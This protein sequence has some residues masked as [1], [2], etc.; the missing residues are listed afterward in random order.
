MDSKPNFLQQFAIVFLAMLL[1]VSC[2]PT[3]AAA[4][5]ETNTPI[6]TKT[7]F[8]TVPAT[9][10][11]QPVQPT[12]T[13]T[14]S[15]SPTPEPTPVVFGP[16]DFPDDVNPLTGIVVEDPQILNRRPVMVKVSNYPRDGRPHAGLSFA[17]IVFDYY[18]GE[19]TNRF[20]ALFYGQDTEKA[21]PIR[22]ARLID[23]QLVNMYQ[24]ILGFSGADQWRVFPT[25]SSILGPRA[26]AQGQNTCP[27]ICSDGP[28]TVTSVFSDTAAL[29]RYAEQVHNTAAPNIKKSLEGNLFDG[30]LPEVGKSADTL[31]VQFNIQNLG[32]WRFDP[33]TGKYLRWIES[34]DL[35]GNISLVPLTDRLTQEQLAFSN[36]VI[37]FVPY[38]QHSPTLHEVGLWNN[39]EGR[40]AVLFRDGMAVEGVWKS[41]SSDRP[42]QFYTPEGDPLP[43]KPGNTWI[44]ITGI[45]ST[46]EE[47][48]AGQ[49]EMRFFLP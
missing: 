21:G 5:T 46:L 17:D 29:S 32:E 30:N 37:M 4:P 49:W 25:I 31:L 23:G 44:V 35:N 16:V 10:T 28:Q 27:G 2:R 1:L 15:P 9:D 8:P 41:G 39:W 14:V 24:G 36:V 13:E 26:I 3:T 34:A 47:K 7:A 20:L 45:Y 19:G 12:P 18:I 6:P 38:T 42:P 11:P 48:S 43:F 22:S 40:R 33:E